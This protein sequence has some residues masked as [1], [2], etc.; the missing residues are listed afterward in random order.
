MKLSVR[1]YLGVLEMFKVGDEVVINLNAIPDYHHKLYLSYFIVDKP[2]KVSSIAPSS[3]II[4]V[5]SE[6]G[7]TAATLSCFSIYDPSFACTI[8]RKILSGGIKN[9]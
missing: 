6:K 9:V 8:R 5:G 1:Y 2:Y 7:V 3:S 4:H